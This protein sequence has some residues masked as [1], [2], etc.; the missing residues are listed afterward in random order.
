MI[1][2]IAVCALIIGVLFCAGAGAQE[3]TVN[4]D[5]K[6]AI[7]IFRQENYDEA[8]AAFKRLNQEYPQDSLVAYYLGLTYKRMEDYVSAKEYLEASLELTPKIK[9]ALIELIDVLY[10]INELDEAKKWIAVAEEEGIRPAQAAFLKG[11]TLSRSGE[12]EGAVTAFERAKNLDNELA[13]S[14]DYQIG[15]AYM[16]MKDFE[17]A[18]KTFGRLVDMAPETD[19]AMY[20]QKCLDTIDRRVDRDRPLHLTARFA[21]E[22]DSNVL[23][24]PDDTTFVTAI[25]DNS[26]TRQVWDF[27]GDY[28]YKPDIDFLR[29]K[30]SYALRVSKQNDF[31][32]Y[33][34]ASNTFTVQPDMAFGNALV[35]FP[36]QYSHSVVADKNYVSVISAGGMGNMMVS[37]T[38]MVQGGVNYTYD[39]YLR[40]PYGDEDRSGSGLTGSC[41]WFW[42]MLENQGFL[43]L[44]YAANK[45]W[46]RG[47]NWPYWGNKFDI[48]CLIPFWKKIKLG[49]NG[50]FFLQNFDNM[51]ATYEKRRRDATY[52]VSS[53]LSFEF[54]KGGE[55]QFQ[56]TFVD[57]ES[58]IGLYEYNR[59]VISAGIQ[60]RF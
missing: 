21:F 48:G 39:D 26:D 52:S 25:T 16:R 5:V 55:I 4:E 57:N 22:Y 23:L 8:L 49:I 18:K 13:S 24:K 9:G 41:G 30:S 42:F 28:V 59:Q 40:P 29:V 56:Y 12:Y 54:M 38:Q 19:I 6:K 35:S 32:S 15:V 44:R 45:D 2:R 50:E 20:A 47:N 27:R 36:V 58:N 14:A 53:I 7:Y 31:G 43:S 1:S 33:D 46:A 51:H 10:R 3:E 11:L 17:N 34:M 37:D 60:Y